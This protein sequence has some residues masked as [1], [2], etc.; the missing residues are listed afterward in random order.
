[1][2]YR[3]LVIGITIELPNRPTPHGNFTWKIK[4]ETSL[5]A[6]LFPSSMSACPFQVVSWRPIN[7]DNNFEEFQRKAPGDIVRLFH[8]CTG[9]KCTA[10]EAHLRWSKDSSI[11]EKPWK[12][13]RT[14]KTLHCR[15]SGKM[16]D[17]GRNVD[18]T[19][20]LSMNLGSGRVNRNPHGNW[21]QRFLLVDGWRRVEWS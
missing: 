7:L 10:V 16:N 18:C 3:L 20:W 17:P 9:R 19:L 8:R 15:D 1:M 4:N 14:S 5:N 13:L 11:Q 21:L 6:L 2:C 12:I